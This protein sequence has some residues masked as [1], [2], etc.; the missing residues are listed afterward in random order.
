[1]LIPTEL[2]LAFGNRRKRLG[3][4]NLFEHS[5]FERSSRIRRSFVVRVAPFGPHGTVHEV[6]LK[7]LERCIIH[8][9]ANDHKS[10]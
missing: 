9:F 2:A 10:D 1:M 8:M 6:R 5:F 4:I 7:L 3:E